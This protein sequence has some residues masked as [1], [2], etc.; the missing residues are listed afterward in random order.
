MMSPV[1]GKTK[2][3]NCVTD[4]LHNMTINVDNIDKLI[5]EEEVRPI[6]NIN[7]GIDNNA[8][9]R[10]LGEDIKSKENVRNGYLREEKKLISMQERLLSLHLNDK[11]N[12]TLFDNKNNDIQ[13]QLASLKKKMQRIDA[14]INELESL[15]E[16][17]KKSIVEVQ[18]INYD[19]VTDDNIK[20]E[21]IRKYID[22]IWVEKIANHTYRLEF[23]YRGCIIPQRGIYI[24]KSSGGYIKVWR[25]NEDETEDRIV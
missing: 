19:N 23:E 24:Y 18:S 14:E 21:L 22:K 11:I 9:I 13:E 20:I 12:A 8:K 2:A 25:I 7:A 4:K 3:Y 16:T 17:T 1:G 5:W 15:S 6:A 10:Q